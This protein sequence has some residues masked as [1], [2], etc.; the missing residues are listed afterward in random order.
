MAKKCLFLALAGQ[1]QSRIGTWERNQRGAPRLILFL[2]YEM[3]SAAK[4][5]RAPAWEISDESAQLSPLQVS[6]RARLGS[7]TCRPLVLVF[8]V[9]GRGAQGG[10]PLSWLELVP[11]PPP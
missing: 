1:L 10:D 11:L 3:T 6:D 2:F 7:M 8:E 5:R 4:G 9:R